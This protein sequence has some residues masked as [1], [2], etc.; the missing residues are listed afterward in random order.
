VIR[1]PVTAKAASGGSQWFGLRHFKASQFWPGLILGFELIAVKTLGRFLCFG[2]LCL[3]VLYRGCAA[4]L[5]ER[6]GAEG[7]V[8]DLGAWRG[9]VL[10]RSH[11]PSPLGRAKLHFHVAESAQQAFK[12]VT[13]AHPF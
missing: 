8:C 10:H 1:F 5:V 13:V 7:K 2:C 3:P 9:R 11:E 4:G 12:C 6:W